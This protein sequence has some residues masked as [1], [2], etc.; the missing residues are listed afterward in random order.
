MKSPFRG[1]AGDIRGRASCYKQDWIAGIRP[2]I[3]ILAPTTYIFFASALP[4]IAFGEQ[5]SRDTEKSHLRK[6]STL[7]ELLITTDRFIKKKMMESV[8]ES[9]EQEASISEIYN[10]MQKVFIDIDNSPITNVTVRELK[11]LEEAIMSVERVGGNTK[12]KFDPEKLIDAYL[13]VRVNE[14]RV[15]NFLQSVL[16]AASL[17]AMPV[18]ILIPTSVLW[19][20]FAY[21]A[22]DSLPGNQFWERVCLLFVP[23][24]QRYKFLEKVHTDFVKMVPYRTIVIFTVFQ[25]VYFLACFGVTWI[26]IAGILFPILFFLL[27]VIRQYILPKMFLPRHLN[28]LDADEFEETEGG[29]LQPLL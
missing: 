7:S 27:I 20:Y 16:L 10:Q 13:P 12:E 22:I 14:Q 8:N 4:V 2:G 25:I 21:M 19:G 11:D 24:G 29:P 23:Y 6:K 3:R 18:I 5:L 15:S 9:I 17:C 28:E 1:I 26:P